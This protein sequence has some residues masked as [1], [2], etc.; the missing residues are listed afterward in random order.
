M[1]DIVI[2]GAGPSGLFAAYELISK[3]NGK[4]KWCLLRST[5]ETIKNSVLEKIKR[6]TK[7]KC[8]NQLKELNLNINT[9]LLIIKRALGVLKEKDTNICDIANFVLSLLYISSK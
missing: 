9:I 6:N 4:L 3:C 8:I 2:V 5:K 7:V 1:N